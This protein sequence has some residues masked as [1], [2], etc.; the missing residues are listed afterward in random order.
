MRRFSLLLLLPIAALAAVAATALAASP[1]ASSTTSSTG[2]SATSTTPDTI[3]GT[4]TPTKIDS[5][6]PGSVELG[7]KFTTSQDGTITGIRF[8]KASDNLGTHTGALYTAAGKLLESVTFS[9]ETASGWQYAKF[10][11]PVAITPGTTYIAAYYAPHGHY[12]ATTDGLSAS[13]TSGPLT[14]LGGSASPDG[15][16]M[17][18]SAP[19]FPSDTY[20]D[21]NYYVDVEFVPAAT[22]TTT[23]S[24]TP[25]TPTP[26]GKTD[27]FASPGVCGFPSPTSGDVGAT[28]ACSSLAST[29]NL[30]ASTSGETVENLDI[31]GTLT[32]AAPN[33]TVKN[34]CVTTNGDY[35]GNGVN[36]GS[37]ATNLLIESSTVSGTASS[38]TGVLNTGVFNPSNVKPVTLNDVYI[39]D[40]A[41]DYHGAGTIENSY[42]QAGGYYD[43]PDGT[44]GCDTSGGCPS[45]N[46]DVYMSD[47]SVTLNHDTLLNSASQTAVLFGDNNGGSKGTPAD[48]DW[49]VENSLIAGGGY[50]AYMDAGATGVGSSVMTV[51]NDR[52]ARCL[53][54]TTFNG[55]GTMC[56]D[57]TNTPTGTS[58]DKYGYYP[59]GGYYGAVIDAYCPGSYAGQTWSGNVWDDNN[60]A[61]TCS[62]TTSS[63]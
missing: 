37:N 26:A 15:V 47:T 52:F 49:V 55:W 8:Y 40:A 33:V 43:A 10:A 34:V 57:A 20:Q 44:G 4:A 56:T 27:C 11:T 51:E 50:V 25:T 58:G 18:A 14:A 38:G 36:I 54:A 59:Y 29:G 45:H 7:V 22:A 42:L 62:G 19:A 2:S 13:K 3:F 41:E 17:Y 5:G 24:T 21:N 9:G 1:S 30:T 16:Y 28:S 31:K 35:S 39:T 53:G 61:V 60:A 46:E 6:D 63:S 23:T 12:S 32:I 48:N